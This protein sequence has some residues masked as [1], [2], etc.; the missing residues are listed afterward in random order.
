MEFHLLIAYCQLILFVRLL[1]QLN[2]TFTLIQNINTR[3]P[4]FDI[5]FDNII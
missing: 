2:N 1:H 5:W 3:Q 4:I